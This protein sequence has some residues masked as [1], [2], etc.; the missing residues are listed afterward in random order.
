LYVVDD[1]D[2]AHPARMMVASKTERGNIMHTGCRV[3]G[4]ARQRP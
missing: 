4:R 2:A 3:S 1:D